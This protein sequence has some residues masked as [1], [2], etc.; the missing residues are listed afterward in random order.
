VREEGKIVREALYSDTAELRRQLSL[1]EF[2]LEPKRDD[3]SSR[4][5]FLARGLIF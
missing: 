2:H 5:A 1:V 4:L 3:Q